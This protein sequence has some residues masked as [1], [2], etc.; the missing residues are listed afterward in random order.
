M[1]N[2]MTHL[3]RKAT[4]R[5][6]EDIE[7]GLLDRDTVIIACVEYMSEDEVAAMCNYNEFFSDDE[8]DEVTA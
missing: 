5:L 6:L 8:D 7:S 4:N 2:K 1:E 3:T